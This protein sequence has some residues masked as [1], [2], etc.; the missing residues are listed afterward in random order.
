MAFAIV[1]GSLDVFFCEK[2]PVAHH[3]ALDA[4]GAQIK[5]IHYI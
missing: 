2:Q 4:D 3:N 1:N 5:L